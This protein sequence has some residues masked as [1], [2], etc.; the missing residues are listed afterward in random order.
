MLVVN[1]DGEE[2]T[3]VFEDIEKLKSFQE[4]M[5]RFLVQTGWRFDEFSPDRRT[6]RDRRGFPRPGN[7]RRRWWTDGRAPVPTR[8]QRSRDED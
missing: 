4:D 7:D 1:T 6:G 8:S 2:R 5:E 3:Y